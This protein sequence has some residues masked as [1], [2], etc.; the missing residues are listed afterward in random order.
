[1]EFAIDGIHDAARDEWD[2]RENKKMNSKEIE[3]FLNPVLQSSSMR[4]EGHDVRE[5]GGEEMETRKKAKAYCEDSTRCGWKFGNEKSAPNTRIQCRR[6]VT[7]AVSFQVTSQLPTNCQL[8]IAHI[9]T[10]FLRLSNLTTK[11]RETEQNCSGV[12]I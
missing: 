8:H 10:Y 9:Y 11:Q 7:R 12:G 6:H 3:F 1:M 2:K 5:E 4:N